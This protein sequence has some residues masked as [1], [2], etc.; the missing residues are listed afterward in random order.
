MLNER[1]NIVEWRIVSDFFARK[2]LLFLVA[3]LLHVFSCILIY[4]APGDTGTG[5]FMLVLSML[6]AMVV[7]EISLM[8]PGRNS[9][10]C[11]VQLPV[12]KNLFARTHWFVGVAVPTLWTCG[13]TLLV[14]PLA[15]TGSRFTW[16][17]VVLTCSAAF[18]AVGI[19]HCL[20]ALRVNS[21]RLAWRKDARTAGPLTVLF[22]AIGM[23][24]G[25]Y[26]LVPWVDSG[27]WRP[28]A[29]VLLVALAASV[30]GFARMHTVITAE[31]STP[32]L[33]RSG[34]RSNSGGRWVF[35]RSLSGFPS[36]AAFSVG[37]PVLMAACVPIG[38][39]LAK[40]MVY[41]GGMEPTSVRFPLPTNVFASLFLGYF[42]FFGPFLAVRRNLVPRV[43]LTLPLSPVQISV[44]FTL[45]M[46]GMAL[47]QLAVGATGLYAAGTSADLA[48]L[49][50][51]LGAIGAGSLGIPGFLAASHRVTTGLIAL[52]GTIA[53]L[54][55]WFFAA[56]RIGAMYAIALVL[57]VAGPALSIVI[58]KQVIV[59]NMWHGDANLPAHQFHAQSHL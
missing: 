50:A 36:I 54:F 2:S 38:L 29:W 26:L 3:S 58:S 19:W 39:L 13:L 18:A 40:G 35:L 20:T 52:L 22:V 42:V 49:F 9:G 57:F 59:R 37:I 25:G 8:A 17:S 27:Q 11:L 55:A 51:L 5:L 21:R 6:L 30:I 45:L 44:R 47:V 7:A 33:G 4:S 53:G 14:S 10:R 12:E 23:P 31:R 48:L 28:V 32:S 24:G 41:L 1:K 16:M 46:V 43:I 34:F 15:A 56:P